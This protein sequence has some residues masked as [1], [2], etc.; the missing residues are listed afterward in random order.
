VKIFLFPMR[1]GDRIFEDDKTSKMFTYFSPIVT[2]LC[3][4]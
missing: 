4:R 2:N 1:R 3:L